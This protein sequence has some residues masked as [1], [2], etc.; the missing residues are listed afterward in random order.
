VTYDF[1]DRTA[2]VVE[3]DPLVRSNTKRILVGKGM[4]VLETS[5]AV[6]ALELLADEFVEPDLLIQDLKVA[7][8]VGLHL[9]RTM[10]AIRPELPI[11]FTSSYIDE[12]SARTAFGG[13]GW[14][15]LEKPFSGVDLLAY[16][17]T[18]LQG[19]SPN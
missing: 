7:D 18:A 14:A 11:L 2:L 12:A 13:E 3:P 17:A 8:M 6:E 4:T 15:L 16:C 9:A 5:S 1:W 10:R 19:G